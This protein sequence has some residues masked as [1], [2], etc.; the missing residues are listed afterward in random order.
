MSE[1]KASILIVDDLLTFSRAGRAEM[2]SDRVDM[3][4]MARTSAEEIVQNAG[5]KG[6]ID[7]R[8]GDLPP[9]QGSASLLK[10]VWINLLSNAVKFSAKAEHPL[11]E[12]EGAL[13]GDNAV[14]RVRDHGA[15]F[16]MANVEKLFG[17][18]Q[19]LHKE[20]DFEGTGIGLA[21]VQRILAR[22][23]GRI[24][25]EGEVGKG[26]TFSFSLPARPRSDG[27]T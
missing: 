12:I 13:D 8:I 23:G 24:W 27:G 9:V 17:V 21:L 16:D 15:G 10:Q 5:L 25:A 26:A 22:H 19:R 14:F 4:E 18:F 11:I 20:S 1:R 7:F 2:V 6:P 3:R